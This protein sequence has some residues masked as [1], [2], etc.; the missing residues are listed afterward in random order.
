MTPPEVVTVVDEQLDCVPPELEDALPCVL[1]WPAKPLIAVILLGP[2]A[3][4]PTKWREGLFEALV[5][6]EQLPELP[7]TPV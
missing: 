6:V 7:L 1:L 4:F 3:V 2:S 5:L